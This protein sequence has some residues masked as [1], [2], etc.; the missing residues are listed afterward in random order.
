MHTTTRS[1]GAVRLAGRPGT[2]QGPRSRGH[3][4]RTVEERPGRAGAEIPHVLDVAERRFEALT[5]G[6]APLTVDGAA[7]GHGLPARLIG[8]DELRAILLHPATMP[9]TRD[10]VWRD[11]VTR[12]RRH[13]PA[14][15]V[16]CVGVVLPGL[17]AAVRDQLAHLDTGAQAGTG[18]VAGDL[19]A[20]F[21]HALPR[22][23]LDRPRIA[24]RL[25][26]RSV[27]AVVR[28]DQAHV[29]TVR[30]DP[31]IMAALEPAATSTSGHPE[32]LLDAAARQGVITAEEAELIA[33]T[34]LERVP[35]A[36]LAERSG[37]SYEALMKRR[38]RAEMRLVAAM[39][40]DDGLRDDYEYLMSTT[41]V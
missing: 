14:W 11:L 7:L 34:R 41:G 35:P 5:R 17:K 8:L 19:L 38:R 23:D 13:G 6:P 22:I 30:V 3:S 27:K 1:G 9:G 37:T 20:A 26:S 40:R 28:A 31:S 2:S 18:R 24:Q 25:V 15:V 33:V 4:F 32:M 12:A 36:V 10:L 39:R 16:G 21:F 29:R